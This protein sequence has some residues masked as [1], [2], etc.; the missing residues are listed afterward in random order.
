MKLE[1]MSRNMLRTNRKALRENFGTKFDVTNLNK[2]QTVQLLEKVST[3]ITETKHSS[4]HH[5][6]H[7][8]PAYLKLVMMESALWSHYSGFK[9]KAEIV[10]EGENIGQAQV[11]LA[12]KDMVDSIQKM[13]ERASD[14]MVKELPAVVE[15]IRTQIG[16]AE[17]KQYNDS[18]VEALRAMTDALMQAKSSMQSSMDV[19]NGG[20]AD[21]EAFDAPEDDISD[22]DSDVE[23]FDDVPD[24]EPELDIPA[25]EDEETVGV[26][27]GKR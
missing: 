10:T 7:N 23:D 2:K 21:I 15:A 5:A 27:R 17:G 11:L 18:A 12:A 14:M 20:E 9:G 25:E 4:K 19:M 6:S 26:G 24:M 13:V 3:L 22:M 8:D 1:E 16:T